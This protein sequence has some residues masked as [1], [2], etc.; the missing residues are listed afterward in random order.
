MVGENMNRILKTALLSLACTVGF[1]IMIILLLLAMYAALWI[2]VAL[3]V[4]T[5]GWA[6]LVEMFLLTFYLFARG[7][8]KNLKK[9]SKWY[10]D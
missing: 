6:I 4:I 10:D 5:N 7:I 3:I 1:A 8:N 9:G 2:F